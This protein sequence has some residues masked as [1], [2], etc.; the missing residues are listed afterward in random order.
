MKCKKNICQDEI[1][2]NISRIEDNLIRIQYSDNVEGSFGAFTIND[3]G[4]KFTSVNGFFLDYLSAYNIPSGFRKIADNNLL[5]QNH[6]RFPFYC[7]LLNNCD[8]RSAKIF[9]AKE[10]QVLSLPVIQYHYGESKDNF[11]SESHLFAFDLCT[12]EE[13]KVMKRICS[14]MNAVLKP[15]FERRNA[16]LAEVDCYFG[17]DEEKLF[18]VDDFTPSSLKVI[19]TGNGQT[20]NPYKIRNVDDFTLYTD[21]IS[22]LTN[23]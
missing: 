8:K 22:N 15:F 6:N 3:I 16:I 11:I 2:K 4:T 17:K 1:G 14:K 5:I 12:M 13:L 9:S 18:L 19:S 20:V 10:G 21:F 23:I 7:K